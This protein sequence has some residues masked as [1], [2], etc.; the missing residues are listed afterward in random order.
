MSDVLIVT[1]EH[2]GNEVPPDY[3]SLF[4]DYSD[5]LQTHRGWDPGAKQLAEQMASQFNAPLFCA[6]TTRL[7]ID[8][9]RSIGHKNLH[10]EATH[11]LPLRVRRKIAAQHYTPHRDAVFA[12]VAR[13]IDKGA[14]VVHIASH[15]FTPELNGVVRLADVSCLYDSRRANEGLFAKSWLN[16]VHARMPKLVLRRNYPYDGKEDGLQSS[17]RRLYGA[18]QYV[19][20]ELEVNQKFVF[21]GGSEWDDLR[22]AVCGG[23][24]EALS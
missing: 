3:A 16:A 8:L 11:T 14:R 10:S 5:L 7:L 19:G 1:C 2:G 4:V 12:A 13:E 9:N 20:I 6:T 15:S 23:L 22:L 17:L 24:Q 21:A 18:D